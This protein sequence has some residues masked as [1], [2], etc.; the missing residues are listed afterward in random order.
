LSILEHIKDSADI[1]SCSFSEL[2]E[3]CGDIRRELMNS[4]SVTGGHLASNLGVVELTVALHNVYDPMKDRIV[5][6]VG[7]Q[8]YVHKMLTGR[9]D[10]FSTLRQEDGL[11][12]FPKPEES[13]TDAFVAGHASSSVSIALGM[14]R[15]RTLTKQDYDVV[16]LLGDGALSG[17][18]AYEGLNNAG[19]SREPLVIVLNDNGIAINHPVGGVAKYLGRQ[20]MKP[21]YYRMKRFY[22]R[23]LTKTKAGTKVF[24]V[25]QRWKNKLKAAIFSCTMFEEMGFRYLGPVDG[26]NVKQLSYMLKVAKCYREPVLLHVVTKKGKGYADAEEHP[27]RYHSVG[28]FDPDAGA[29]PSGRKCFSAVFGEELCSLAA[30]DGRIC[31]I[32]AAMEEGTGLTDFRKAFPDRFFDEGIAE[33]HAVSMAAGMAKQGLKPV[34]A[35]YSTFLQRSYDMLQQD[36]ALLRLPVV[37]A[38]DRAGLVGADGETHQ[39]VFDVGYLRQIP[40]MRIWSPASYGELRDMLKAALDC[41]GPA[42]VRYPRGPEGAFREGGAEPLRTLRRG[43]DVALVSYGVLI[44][45]VLEAAD[46]LAAEGVGATVIKLGQLAPLD[47]KAL[48]SLTYDARGVLVAEEAAA[49]GCVGEQIAASLRRLPVKLL[50]LGDGVVRQGTVAQQRRRRGIDAASIAAAAKE[51][52]K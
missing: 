34:F 29:Q 24:E 45:E 40:G 12:G 15:A 36:V 38:V 5:F 41:D 32:T 13:E 11:S 49:E 44:N 51:M 1:R 9:L 47:M 2:E 23:T 16:A 26:H 4:V 37:L 19:Q 17:G 33:G 21:A 7:H 39:G 28:P 30:R 6:D 50:N 31:A 25:T 35:V 18:L 20:R 43:R 42:A 8:C 10:R 48:D 27:E 52:L 22:R 3:L 46:L 14:A